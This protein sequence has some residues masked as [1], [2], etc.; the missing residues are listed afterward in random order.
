MVLKV[1]GDKMLTEPEIFAVIF[2][3]GVIVVVHL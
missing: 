2:C 1:F 3:Y